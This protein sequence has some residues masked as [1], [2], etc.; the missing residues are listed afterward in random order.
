MIGLFC[1]QA[2]FS[3][4]YWSHSG[5]VGEYTNGKNI[6]TQEAGLCHARTNQLIIG[7]VQLS[8]RVFLLG[9]KSI[10]NRLWSN[11]SVAY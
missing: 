5:Q 1:R 7:Y 2:E 3:I 4:D 11:Y 8:M 10:K 6:I 9:D